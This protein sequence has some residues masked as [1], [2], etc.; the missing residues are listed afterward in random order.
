[1]PTSAQQVTDWAAGQQA[2]AAIGCA[3]CH[4]P[5]LAL[6]S[7]VFS[8]APRD[9]G[10]STRIDLATHGAEPRIGEARDDGSYR[11]YLFSDLKRHVVGPHLREARA[12]RGISQAAFLTRPLWGVARSRPYMHDARA[13]TLEEAILAH[14]GEATA[15]R[16]A[17][18]ALDDQARA[19]IRIYLTSLTRAPRLV[20]P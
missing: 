8:F 10:P 14:S 18:A 7:T 13:P 19:P 1:M 11:V 15:A 4:V 20:S 16:D 3:A 12:Y 5:A 9:G 6:R 2:F 17:Y